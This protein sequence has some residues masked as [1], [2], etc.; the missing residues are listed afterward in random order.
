MR[1]LLCVS[2][3]E[4]S[5]SASDGGAWKV[6]WKSRGLRR[7]DY[8]VSDNGRCRLWFWGSG[9]AVRVGGGQAVCGV[10]QNGWDLG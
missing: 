2:C 3:S 7:E 8:W 4:L 1:W 10:D 5:V 6:F 9:E